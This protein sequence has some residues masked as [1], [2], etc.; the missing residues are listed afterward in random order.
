MSIFKVTPVLKLCLIAGLVAS[1]HVNALT[2][3]HQIGNDAHVQGFDYAPLQVYQVATRVGKTTLITLE[4]GE[5]VNGDNSG[6]GLGDSKAWKVAMKGNNIFIKPAGDF[7]DTNMVIVTNKRTYAFELVTANGKRPTS[8]IVK[9]S[10]PD[11]NKALNDEAARLLQASAAKQAGINAKVGAIQPLVENYN[12]QML[13]NKASLVLAPTRLHDDGRFTYFKYA[14]GR[15][16][17]AIYKV[18]ADGTEALVN[19]HIE[20]DTTVVHE[21]NSTYILRLGQLVIK[22]VNKQANQAT[23]FNASGTSVQGAIRIET[24]VAQ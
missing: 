19:S 11:T 14:N 7:P 13:S 17:P 24:G 21:K 4:D 1:T 8:Y 15:D 12:Y 16:L 2:L 6:F 20:G 23:S 22:I 18:M 3:P 10:Y 5:V 9:F